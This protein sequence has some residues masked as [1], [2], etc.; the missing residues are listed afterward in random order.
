MAIAIKKTAAIAIA[1]GLTFAGSA[2]IAAQ[3]ALAQTN[4]SNVTGAGI[5]SNKTLSLTLHKKKL[6]ATETPGG[7]AT[8]EAMTGVP[9][10]GLPNVSYR[11]DLIQPL[12]TDKDWQE[13]SAKWKDNTTAGILGLDAKQEGVATGTTDSNGDVTF[14]ELEKGL[15]RVVE[16][17]APAGVV[18]GAPFLV[19]VPMTNQT[20][21][22]WIYDVHAYPKNTE[23]TVTKEVTDEWANAGDEYTYT[24]TTGVPTGTLTKYIVRD[25]LDSKLEV[26]T[27]NNKNERVS[28]DGFDAGTDYVVNVSGQ[29]IEVV[30]TETGRGKLQAGTPVKTTITTKTTEAVQHIPNQGVLIY[31]NGSS[32]NDVEQ[33]TNKVHTYWGNLAVTKTDEDTKPLAD[34]EFELVRCSATA[35]TAGTDATWTQIAETGAQNAYSSTA[36]GVQT[37]FVTGNDGKVTISGIHVED[38]ADNSSENVDTNFCLKET[39]APAGYIAD[40]R[41]IP[42]E[43]KR[44]DVTEDGAPV[45][46]IQAAVAVKNVKSPNT[47][48]ATGGMGVLII[49]LAG[50]AIIGGGVYAARRNSQSA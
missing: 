42:F 50:L 26:P 24:L 36:T 29:T 17:N 11:I 33:P 18:P 2:G 37:K 16:T 45:E 21:D 43:L 13:A 35:G 8:G 38:F 41:L 44:G 27:E 14:G 48:P 34:A 19:Y 49:A 28:V 23:N 3:D 12:N 32:E 20:G 5:D 7:Q 40:D 10:A 4:G 39:K 1:A 15:Y 22:D 25:V 6:A 9:G 47:L 30:F 46:T 31:N